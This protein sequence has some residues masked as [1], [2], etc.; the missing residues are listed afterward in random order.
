MQNEAKDAMDE[1]TTPSRT[2]DPFTRMAYTKTEGK[3]SVQSK[4]DPQVSETRYERMQ[5]GQ[6]YFYEVLSASDLRTEFTKRPCCKENC[7]QTL[8]C[9]PTDPTVVPCCN[10]HRP[11]YCAPVNRDSNAFERLVM[12]AREATAKFREETPEAD[13]ALKNFL[14]VK[15]GDSK[16]YNKSTTD[17]NYLVVNPERHEP[18]SVCR[19]AFAA[20]YGI[21]MS[22]INYVQRLLRGGEAV[23]FADTESTK[24]TLKDMFAHWGMDIEFYHQNIANFCDFTAVPETEGGIA[25]AAYLSDFFDLASEHQPTGAYE[26]DDKCLV[27]QVLIYIVSTFFIYLPQPK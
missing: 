22:T 3:Y 14:M 6:R 17:W 8:L 21:K 20:I 2:P 25:A 18:V 11:K 7:I 12:N 1:S 27:T 26:D 23:K 5:H 13:K 10:N 19:Q 24:V 15:L 9:M 16:R 4:P